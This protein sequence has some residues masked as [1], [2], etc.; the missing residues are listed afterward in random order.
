MNIYFLLLRLKLKKFAALKLW[1]LKP[2][3]ASLMQM[4]WSYRCRMRTKIFKMESRHIILKANSP[5]KENKRFLT[6]IQLTNKEF[7]NSNEV[8]YFPTI[9]P[10]SVHDQIS[11][12]ANGVTR[13]TIERNQTSHHW[14]GHGDLRCCGVDDFRCGDV[15]NKI[16]FYGVVV[17]S[18]LTVC[19]GDS[20]SSTFLAV[21]WCSLTFFAVLWF[22]PPSPF[23][24]L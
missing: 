3:R 6:A 8:N 21:M 13:Q 1:N 7:Q 14:G 23:P 11:E 18:N 24:P 2:K 5:R 22:S 12:G 9:S 20:V 10:N 17:I 4:S 19:D 15:V 16:S